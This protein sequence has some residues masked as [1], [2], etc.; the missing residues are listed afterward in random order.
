MQCYSFLPFIGIEIKLS[1]LVAD[2]EHTIFCS[3]SATKPNSAILG[4]NLRLLNIDSPTSKVL[5]YRIS[6]LFLNMLYKTLCTGPIGYSDS[7]GKPKNVNVSDCDSDFQYRPP[8][9]Q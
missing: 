9:L 2:S 8:R 6:S 3:L 4:P 7:A 1:G 5:K